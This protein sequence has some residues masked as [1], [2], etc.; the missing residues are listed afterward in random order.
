MLGLEERGKG[1]VFFREVAMKAVRYSKTAKFV[2]DEFQE[3]ESKLH[4][5]YICNF[6]VFQSVP[7]HWAL[8]Q[9][10]PIIPV[11]RLNEPPTR[12][13][14]LADITCDSDGEVEKF[15][16]L[17]DIKDALE[18]HEL[19]DGEP[20]YLAFALV[21]AYQ[22]TMGDM[23]NLFG[24]V[25]EAEVILGPKD[26]VV[27]DVRRGEPGSET[28]ASFGYDVSDLA[29]AVKAQLR[30]RTNR[31]EI[32]AD[33]AAEILENYTSRLAQYTYLD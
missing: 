24:R 5:K 9:L 33:D 18:V 26:S 22:D 25:N 8:D 21:G 31:G 3:L 15:V 4:D 16:D 19:K 1:E 32:S 28:L 11:H 13:A 29:E 10:F 6:S 23:H 27:T 2:A 7:D 14:T 20:Y 12:K 17:K 30:E